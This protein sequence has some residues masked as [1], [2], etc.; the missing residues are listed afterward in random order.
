MKNF[1][2]N[3]AGWLLATLLWLWTTLPK[4]LDW[5]GRTTLPEDW[6]ALM[7]E[8]LPI[9]AAWL[10]STPWWVPA[11]LATTITVWMM[12][13]SW[14][15]NVL[16]AEPPIPPDLEAMLIDAQAMLTR[17][18]RIAE[19]GRRNDPPTD[20]AST[21]PQKSTLQPDIQ[22][23]VLAPSDFDK[24]ASI[25]ADI[26]HFLATTLYEHVIHG[27]KISGIEKAIQIAGGREPYIQQIRDH[28]SAGD[29]LR[30]DLK[31]SLR[32]KEYLLG[33]MNFDPSR[34]VNGIETLYN[35]G[36]EL[37]SALAGL[38][39]DP[40]VTLLRNLKHFQQAFGEAH[41]KLANLVG[42]TQDEIKRLRRTLRPTNP[43]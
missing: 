24:C 27:S 1:I 41:G 37:V 2:K 29:K 40:P 21:A 5:V 22:Q 8:K 39:D 10:F 3:V 35:P 14:P 20:T 12:W 19:K 18:S 42:Q 30:G 31:K 4:I 11:I 34:L 38:P 23:I 28:I 25:L 36:Q 16:L 43:T 15:R 33:L 7:V 6:R 17:E 9:W 26:D 32:Q 13:V